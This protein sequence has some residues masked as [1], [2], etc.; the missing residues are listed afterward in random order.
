MILWPRLRSRVVAIRSGSDFGVGLPMAPTCPTVP[1][2]V[3]GYPAPMPPR[4][5]LTYASACDKTPNAGRGPCKISSESSEVASETNLEQALTRC[6]GPAAQVD[7]LTALRVGA[8]ALRSWTAT[9]AGDT[10][11]LPTPEGGHCLG[12]TRNASPKWADSSLR[13]AKTSLRSL[14]GCAPRDGAGV[15]SRGALRSSSRRSALVPSHNGSDRSR[16]PPSRLK[17]SVSQG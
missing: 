4:W 5:S 3:L 14:P 11:V 8:L 17:K 13:R 16:T 6:P 1:I 15:S 12:K 2:G 9:T 10:K 7:V